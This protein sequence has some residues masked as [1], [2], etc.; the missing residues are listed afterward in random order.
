MLRLALESFAITNAYSLLASNV[1]EPVGPSEFP[2]ALAGVISLTKVV[3]FYVV[4]ELYNFKVVWNE[5]SIP[6]TE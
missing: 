3:E 2:L 1:L 6:K 5:L 4:E